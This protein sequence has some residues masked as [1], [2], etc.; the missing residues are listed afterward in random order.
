M[1]PIRLASYLLLSLSFMVTG[2]ELCPYHAEYK[3]YRSG[4]KLGK[5]SQQLE[6]LNDHQYR[7]TYQSHASFLFLSDH[8]HEV[9]LFS[10][11]GEQLTSLNYQYTRTGT[12]S[13][14]ELQAVFDPIEH[15][16]LIN[17][18]AYLPWQDEQDN[19]LYQLTIKQYLADG[20]TSFSLP[21]LNYRG[22]KEQYDFALQGKEQIKLPYGKIDALKIARIRDS[23]KRETFIWFAP[24]LNYL[25]VRIR[26]LK[27]G[28]EQLDIRL[29]Q[30]TPETCS[31]SNKSATADLSTNDSPTS[32]NKD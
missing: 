4:S 26:Q 5:A 1:R 30:Y 32:T 29:S 9:S 11:Q 10:Q 16:I 25:M 18:E 24:E 12:G 27:E 3:A 20:Q 13:D 21:V 23:K 2:I 14:K 19:Q 7:L 15:R 8:R 17:N 22:E 6:V 28:D 31:P